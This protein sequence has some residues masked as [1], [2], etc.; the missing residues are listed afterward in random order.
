LALKLLLK[1]AHFGKISP[2]RVPSIAEKGVKA[3][4]GI[5]SSVDVNPCGIGKFSRKSREV[6][7][8]L[9]GWE[10]IG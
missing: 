7:S 10:W 5:G 3:Q 9:D 6:P 2:V 4:G 1:I 8:P